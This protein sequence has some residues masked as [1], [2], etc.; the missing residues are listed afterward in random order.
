M[1]ANELAI[2]AADTNRYSALG[3]PVWADLIPDSGP[4]GGIYTALVNAT[5][6][7]TLVV[8]S[9]MPFVSA[10]FLK[11]L[12]RIGQDVDVAIPQTT[13]SYRPLCVRDPAPYLERRL[14]SCRPA[15]GDERTQDRTGGA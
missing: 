3:V 14:E 13:D 12:V 9:D 2:V 5:S 10:S 11:Y 8:A 15:L 6:S 7:H 1:V 4:L